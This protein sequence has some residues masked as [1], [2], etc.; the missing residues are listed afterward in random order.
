[1]LVWEVNAPFSTRLGAARNALERDGAMIDLVECGPIMRYITLRPF[2]HTSDL[3]D[4]HIKKES[5]GDHETYLLESTLELQSF[6]FFGP[7]EGLRSWLRFLKCD[8]GLNA[9]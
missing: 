2:N 7:F 3:P 4:Q 8:H 5:A 9:R 1:M 6:V